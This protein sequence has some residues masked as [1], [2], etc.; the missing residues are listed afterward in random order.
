MVCAATWK[1][2]VQYRILCFFARCFYIP[3]GG[4]SIADTPQLIVI[5]QSATVVSCM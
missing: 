5:V 2:N 1:L 3:H 4:L